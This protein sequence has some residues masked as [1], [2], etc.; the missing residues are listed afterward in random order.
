MKRCLRIL[1]WIGITGAIL[2]I[3]IL[4]SPAYAYIDEPDSAPSLEYTKCYRNLLETGDF[5][6]IVYQNTPYADPPDIQVDE[7]FVMRLIDTDGVTELG[8]S[9]AYA[10]NASGYGYNIYSFYF[11]AAD[12][13]DWGEEYYLKLTGTPSAFASPPEYNFQI[14]ASDYSALT[15]TADVQAEL[16][17]RILILADDLDNKW[18]LE[19]DYSLLLSTETGTVL[20][21]YGEAFFRGAIYGVQALAPAV[22][23]LLIE[24]VNVDPREW[25]ENFTTT[26]GNQW[27]GTWVSVSEN[28]GKT[29]WGVDFNLMG[30]IMVFLAGFGVVIV[31][32][33]IG[34][35]HWS[36]FLDAAM[37]S[38]IF[39]RISFYGLDFLALGAALCWLYVSSRIWGL[40]R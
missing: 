14:N 13:P 39:A 36:G 2:L 6:I 35:D 19:S 28:A 34:Q 31:N 7:A 20:S 16:A 37:L 5:L 12:A 17:A 24:D 32:I 27:G 33:I 22:F 4:A 38:V 21:I 1:H 30:I 9:L 29:F 10:F 18:G 8:Q 3:F 40:A 25:S 15:E 11:S 26:L 23:R